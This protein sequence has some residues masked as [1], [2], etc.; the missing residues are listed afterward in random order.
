MKNSPYGGPLY[1]APPTIGAVGWQAILMDP[2]I[3]HSDPIIIDPVIMTKEQC[4][5]C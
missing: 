4:S 5:S 3:I 1:Y 2:N